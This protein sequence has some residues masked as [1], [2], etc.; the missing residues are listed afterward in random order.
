MD[1]GG[2]FSHGHF[3]TLLGELQKVA[4][5]LRDSCRRRRLARY[6]YI[7]IYSHLGLATP[8]PPPT[9]TPPPPIETKPFL[10]VL[11]YLDQLRSMTSA[12]VLHSTR[13]MIQTKQPT[14]P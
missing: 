9:H 5:V 6:M 10:Q 1:G 12:S 8:P 14:N 13:V 3:N 11:G 2:N 7:Y 4:Y